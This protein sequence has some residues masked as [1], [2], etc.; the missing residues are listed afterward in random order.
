MGT[1]GLLLVGGR[2]SPVVR[3]PWWSRPLEWRGR[4]VIGVVRTLAGGV[5]PG[6]S[7][8]V[9]GRSW[10]DVRLPGTAVHMTVELLLLLDVVGSRVAL[11]LL[12]GSSIPEC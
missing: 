4:S 5:G 12:L 9:G 11:L 1:G 7:G 6:P 8:P 2:V 3:T 10:G